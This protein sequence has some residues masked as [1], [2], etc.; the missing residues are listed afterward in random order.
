MLFTCLCLL[1]VTTPGRADVTW[2]TI[3]AHEL[4]FSIEMPGEQRPARQAG[5]AAPISIPPLT[6]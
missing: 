2:T 4:G 3:N 5:V 1:V 6:V